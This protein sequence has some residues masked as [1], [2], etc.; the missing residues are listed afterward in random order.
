MVDPEKYIDG[1]IELFK[2][3]SFELS[4]PRYV[5]GL[6]GCE[7]KPNLELDGKV[8]SELWSSSSCK[9]THI[10]LMTRSHKQTLLIKGLNPGVTKRSTLIYRAHQ[11]GGRECRRSMARTSS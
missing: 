4:A 6:T 9:S 2:T 3:G 10:G 11:E 8:E 5:R 7:F 1:G